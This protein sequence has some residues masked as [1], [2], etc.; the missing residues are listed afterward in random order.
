MR[1]QTKP[2][3][4]GGVACQF[5]DDDSLTTLYQGGNPYGLNV[6]LQ[7]CKKGRT[8]T[9]LPIPSPLQSLAQPLSFPDLASR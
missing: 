8:P 7:N 9:N 4:G 1:D 5:I 2:G 6:T 3:Y